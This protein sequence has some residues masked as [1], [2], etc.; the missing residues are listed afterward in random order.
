M[1]IFADPTTGDRK[2]SSRIYTF[3]IVIFIVILG[4]PFLW[5][6]LFTPDKES[7]GGVKE[8]L[9]LSLNLIEILAWIVAAGFARTATPTVSKFITDGK[10]NKNSSNTSV[11]NS[12][13]DNLSSN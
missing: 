8:T 11:N 13:S 10:N 7:I 2:S 5:H 12:R 3:I 6:S 4:L 1:S 9:R